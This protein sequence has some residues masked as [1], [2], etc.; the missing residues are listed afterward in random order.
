M[1]TNLYKIIYKLKYI[2]PLYET[3]FKNFTQWFNQFI[4]QYNEREKLEN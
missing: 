1:T 2:D 3:S 4:F